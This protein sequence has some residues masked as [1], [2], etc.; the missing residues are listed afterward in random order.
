MTE[1]PLVGVG[2]LI[3]RPEHQA[4]ELAAAIEQRGGTAI[5]FPT[6]QISARK[7]A[8][9]A[10]EA[11]QLAR[12]DIV[13]FV[14]SNAVRHGLAIVGD[15]RIAA[16]GP[17][18]AAAVERAGRSVDIVAA[19][20]FDSEHLLAT[21]GLTDVAG[22]T[23]TI[24]RGQDGRELLAS[25]LRERGATVNYLSV[26]E[27]V[28]AAPAA[29]SIAALTSRWEAGEIAV[30]TVMSVA[31]F[32]SLVALLPDTALQMLARTPLVTPAARVLKEVKNQFPDL[33]V[34]LADGPDAAAMVRAIGQIASGRSK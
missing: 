15:A 24:I 34:V 25:T 19:R 13:I 27:R 16:V 29:A 6:L 20:G 3:T 4:D 12:P 14:S 21:A 28:V 2:V 23:I 5:R 33:P 30:V 8:T 26:Y 18:T 9:I 11:R 17:A 10:A 1:L 7:A 22:K 32:S 31:S